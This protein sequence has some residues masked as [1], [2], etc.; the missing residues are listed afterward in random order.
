[1][2]YSNDVRVS[3]FFLYISDDDDDDDDDRDDDDATAPIRRP[4]IFSNVPHT[5]L[6][7]Q[8]TRAW[9]SR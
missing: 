1:M 5:R 9:S 2:S 3:S 7:E 8:L 4:S 6:I